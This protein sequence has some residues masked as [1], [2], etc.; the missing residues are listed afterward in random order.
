MRL[1][2]VPSGVRNQY[3]RAHSFV[4]SNPIYR[5]YMSFLSHDGTIYA[6]AITYFA[7]LSLIPFVIFLVAVISFFIRDPDLQLRITNSIIA[8]LP[9][10]ANLDK[11]IASAVESVANIQ[12]TVLA[13]PA[14]IGAAWTASGFF[15]ALRRS[16]NRAFDVAVRP[17]MVH[18]RL[19]DLAS[20]LGLSLLLLSSTILTITVGI[21]RTRAFGRFDLLYSDRLWSIF[22]AALPVALSF[23]TFLLIFR[24]V[25][26][27][28]LGLRD[29]WI[30]ALFSA[31][32]LE[33]LTRVF[34][35]FVAVV[36]D[37]D[38]VYGALGGLISFLGLIY[39]AAMIVILAA[40][41]TRELAIRRAVDSADHVPDPHAPGSE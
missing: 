11:P 17:S 21:L 34:A 22:F 1:P 3:D 26:Q 6:A 7:L 27:H 9:A 2:A 25:P 24:W 40:E 4:T 20:V 12:S 33:F 8:Y 38:G 13:I 10:D 41:V 19:K 5:A 30:G 23:L 16:L 37:N 29:I 36:A 39:F 31:I 15:G 32:G 14:I 18:A 35:W 28:G